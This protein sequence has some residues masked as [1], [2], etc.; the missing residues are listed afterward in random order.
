MC[1][2]V[3]NMR[4]L[5][6]S[7]I[8]YLNDYESSKKKINEIKKIDIGCQAVVLCGDNAELDPKLTNYHS[9]FK[10][11]R[12]KFDCPIGFVVGN[13]ELWGKKIGES[14]EKLLSEV[15]AKIGREYNIVYLENENLFVNGWSI[16]GTYGHYDYSLCRDGIKRDEI[17]QGKT[18]VNGELI[19]WKD[20]Q[21]M[22]W[23]DKTD[24]EICNLLI[25]NFKG[26]MKNNGRKVITLSHTTPSREFNG[27][28]DSLK[29]RFFEAY[30]G[31]TKLE[32]V[33]RRY[34]SS[35][36]FC[37][38]THAPADGFINK[39]RVINIGSDYN[40]LRYVY[41][42]TDSPTNQLQKKE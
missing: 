26:R 32:D 11:L 24:E 36:H 23:G 28:P 42:D 40:L 34:S 33:L 8:H 37:G 38:H 19:G 15:F 6:F 5:I 31:T 7:D 41:L 16:S 39:T 35:Y 17:I 10:F 9:L 21:Y 20:K 3:I 12:K 4:L 14:S 22:M 18:R 30:S 25:E 27:H 13:H 29:Q 2:L 1:D